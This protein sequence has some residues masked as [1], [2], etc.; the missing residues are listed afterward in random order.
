MLTSWDGYAGVGDKL[1]DRT[2]IEAVGTGRCEAG[3]RAGPDAC[4]LQSAE[5]PYKHE[6]PDHDPRRPGRGE[7]RA[8]LP[9]CSP[10]QVDAGIP[11][12]R[13]GASGCTPAGREGARADPRAEL[14]GKLGRVEAGAAAR[15]LLL[16]EL[17]LVPF[18]PFA[19]RA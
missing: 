15:D 7:G 18:S 4:I 6:S 9:G 10:G 11:A 17:E 14:A 2:V 5:S 8:G 13:A 3:G 19:G 12:C 1:R 16:I